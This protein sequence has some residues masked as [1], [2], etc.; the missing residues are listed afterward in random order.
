MMEFIFGMVVGYLLMAFGQ[1]QLERGYVRDSIAKIYG[2]Y[3][4]I[5]PLNG[6]ENDGRD[7]KND[8]PGTTGD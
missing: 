1:A 8:M 5:T 4:R 7:E 6:G 3:Y 2:K